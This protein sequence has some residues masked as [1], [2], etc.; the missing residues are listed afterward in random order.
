MFN[1][2]SQKMALFIILISVILTTAFMYTS[3]HLNRKLLE[4]QMGEKAKAIALSV[5]TSIN[6]DDFEAFLDSG[7]DQSNYYIQT[8]DYLYHTLKNTGAFYLYT[9]K[10]HNETEYEYLI[11]GSAQYGDETFSYF[12][13]IDLK[14]NYSATPESVLNDGIP[15]ASEIYDGG[16]WGKLIS[17]FAPIKNSNGDI[18][19]IVGCDIGIENFN[20]IAIHFFS[21]LL[22]M[23]LI[24][25]IP[26]IVLFGYIVSQH[27]GKPIL[28]LKEFGKSLSERN[29]T[30]SVSNQ[31]FNRKD[32]LGHL[33]KQMDIIREN[34]ASVL[35]SIAE[36][37]QTLVT[38][39]SEISNH[40]EDSHRVITALTTTTREANTLVNQLGQASNG[41]ATAVSNTQ[42]H[43]NHFV[44][45]SKNTRYAMNT[46]QKMLET[47]SLNS[48]PIRQASS[49]IASI[50]SQ[51]TLLAFN[52]SVEAA[53]AGEKGKGFAVIANEVRKLAIE[54]HNST[55]E[56]DDVVSS[57]L[58]NI[59]NSLSHMNGMVDKSMSQETIFAAS[60]KEFYAI[61][62]NLNRTQSHLNAVEKI[63]E[64]INQ[65]I[66]LLESHIEK[67][68]DNAL[69]EI[70]NELNT[71]VSQFNI[72]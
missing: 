36:S 13:D 30:I 4:K 32:E 22:L 52:A 72:R 11:D 46:T 39:A 65:E 42:S 28:E 19:A 20:T 31:L 58:E 53:R 25:S 16:E 6:G 49:L 33:A 15:R 43:L 29:F 60:Y 17:G 26:L 40:A 44:D 10:S 57:L 27:I 62:E 51:T 63:T 64:D 71:I 69:N 54:S 55:R 50:A 2:L 41:I 48:A 1:K 45:S 34:T 37:A 59:E 18:V 21:E 9:L 47:T 7:T 61:D 67:M 8:Q 24:I 23:S 5:S 68:N 66:I 14:E 70:V 3:V 38:S 56:I 35:E 12:G